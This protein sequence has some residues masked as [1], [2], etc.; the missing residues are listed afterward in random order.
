MLTGAPEGPSG[1]P[2]GGRMA[3]AALLV[4]L[5]VVAHPAI[6]GRII[7]LNWYA[8]DLH[9]E[10]RWA[11]AVLLAAAAALLLF[12]RVI[13]RWWTR[14]G[15]SRREALL[16]GMLVLI[17]ST[18]GLAIAE[19]ALHVLG[20]PFPQSATPSESAIGRF[21]SIE[22]WSYRPGFSAVDTISGRAVAMSFD[23]LG[24]RVEAPGQQTD[25]A[26][27]SV[28]FVG[29][30]FT[31]GHGVQYGESFV[32]QLATRDHLPYQAVNL[33]VQG[34]GTDQSLLALEEYYPRFANVR[35]VVYTFICDHMRRNA[36]ADRRLLFPRDKF[37]G[38]K[39]AFRLTRDGRLEERAFAHRYGGQPPFRLWAL[40]R[41]L[42]TRH[43]PRA[44]PDLTLAL[45]RA[46][47]RY[48]E[49][50]GSRFILVY[51]DQKSFGDEKQC[52]D[53][54]FSPSE[55]DMIDT[56]H[57][58]PPGWRSWILPGDKHPSPPAH[59]YVADLLA[60]ELE[61]VPERSTSH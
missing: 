40:G 32:G 24:I 46:M 10:A 11:S 1:R 44:E 9:R 50:H 14:H 34:Y 29:G 54:R 15:V 35:A 60:R 19:T 55:F 26:A 56:R 37:L 5:G 30:S 2:A 7:S 49:A 47:K 4:A 59:A 41:V 21:D 25:L 18:V 51:W 52:D 58:T 45:V 27:P 61:R 13:D 38:T 6:L 3:L 36:V 28:L 12:G 8:A 17:G 42:W 16:L 39:P 53:L 43:G 33:G 57:G 31:F 22:G 20:L 48:T 23:S